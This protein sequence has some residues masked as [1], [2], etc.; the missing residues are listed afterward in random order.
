MVAIT[1]EKDLPPPTTTIPSLTPSSVAD[2]HT[3]VTLVPASGLRGDS[4]FVGHAKDAVHA[5]QAARVDAFQSGWYVP[6]PHSVGSTEPSGQYAPGG[7][8]MQSVSSSS[9]P[10]TGPEYEPA[11]Q[12]TGAVLLAFGHVLPG[13]Q[14]R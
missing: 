10:D 2:D 14:M 13:G 1:N 4:P 7:H 12:G 3:S 5:T 11:W 8:A 9:S 6:G